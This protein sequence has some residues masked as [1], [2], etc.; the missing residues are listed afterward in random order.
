MFPPPIILVLRSHPSSNSDVSPRTLGSLLTTS[1][2]QVGPRFLSDEPTESCYHK[3]WQNNLG[4]TNKSATTTTKCLLTL[5]K[6]NFS[7]F[8]HC[9][10]SV[11][12]GYR[13]LCNL[14]QQLFNVWIISCSRGIA[15]ESDS[16]DVWLRETTEFKQKACITNLE[17]L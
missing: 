14:W 9:V 10:Q 11:S 2:F 7:N 13:V 15:L 17:K 8:T 6:E 12:D 16:N 3:S 5:W 4:V 1:L